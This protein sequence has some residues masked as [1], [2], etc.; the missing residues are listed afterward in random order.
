MEST[1]QVVAADDGNLIEPGLQR[2]EQLDR[3]GDV[4]DFGLTPQICGELA[5]T[6]TAFLLG[7]DL[8]R[9]RDQVRLGQ[10]SQALVGPRPTLHRF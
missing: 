3:L 7:R 2:D 10:R 5:A 1:Q 9:R 6:M 4:E 8:Q